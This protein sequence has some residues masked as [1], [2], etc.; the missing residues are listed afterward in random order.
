[1]SSLISKHLC[2]ET[3]QTAEFQKELEDV[4]RSDEEALPVKRNWMK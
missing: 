2:A 3:M 4:R 1:M